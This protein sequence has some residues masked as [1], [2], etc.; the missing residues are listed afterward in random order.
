MTISR[1]AAA[2][3]LTATLALTGCGGDDE[4]AVAA[5]SAQ[6][7]ASAYAAPEITANA[8]DLTKEPKSGAGSGSVTA[9]QIKDLVV[10][11]G[12]VAKLTDT[13]TVHYVG[14]LFSDGKVFDSSWEG[15]RPISFSL[16]R[17]VPGFAQGIEGMKIGGRRQIVIPGD[18][19]YGPNPD[20]RSGIPPNAALV[21]V[22]DLTAIG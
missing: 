3:F 5:D 9:L 7:N 19:A 18:L 14:T 13:V 12:K 15:G 2:L 20:P 4:P 8:T 16:A 11:K 22:V 6:N 17:V 1:T 21:F 10:G